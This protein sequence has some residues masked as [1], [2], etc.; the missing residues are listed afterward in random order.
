MTWRRLWAREH[1]LSSR[2]FAV[3]MSWRRAILLI[4]RVLCPFSSAVAISD[5]VLSSEGGAGVA[6]G[7]A[8]EVVSSP[9]S[10]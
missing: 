8:N 1:N 10:S 6:D 3:R 9:V 4:F 2:V 7:G 5:A